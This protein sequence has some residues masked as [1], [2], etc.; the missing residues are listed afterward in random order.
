MEYIGFQGGPI[1]STGLHQHLRVS[2][3]SRESLLR[4]FMGSPG[5]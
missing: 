4:S 3:S 2:F 1:G 5:G